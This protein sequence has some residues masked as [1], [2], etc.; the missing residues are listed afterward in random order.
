MKE[1]DNMIDLYNIM[2]GDVIVKTIMLLMTIVDRNLRIEDMMIEIFTARHLVVII[3]GIIVAM[4]RILIRDDMKRAIIIVIMII[5]TVV[6][7]VLSTIDQPIIPDTLVGMFVNAADLMT[8][9]GVI[10]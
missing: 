8:H 10:G 5:M 4:S 7:Q 9:L 6:V 1:V 2:I 3:A